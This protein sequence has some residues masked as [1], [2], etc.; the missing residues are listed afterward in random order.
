[1]TVPLADAGISIFAVSTYDTDY[2]LVKNERLQ[3]A[4]DTLT[5]FGHHVVVTQSR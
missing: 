2:M 4:I 5:A 3:T 1:L